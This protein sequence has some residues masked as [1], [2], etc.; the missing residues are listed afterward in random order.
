MIV[1]LP[2]LPVT[3]DQADRNWYAVFTLPQNEKS[4][5]R[6][7]SLREIEFFLPTYRTAR[8]WKNRQRVTLDIPL[9][10]CYLFARISSCER[11]KVLESPG[12]LRIV[13][14]R[15]EPTPVPDLA[16][17]FLRSGHCSRGIEPYCGMVVGKKVRIKCGAFEGL[18]GTLIRMNT[19]LRFVLTIEL[20]N[21]NASVEVDANSLELLN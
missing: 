17:E 6:H 9:F 5:A 2:G 18:E 21:Q 15:R 20:I 12:V 13:G 19:N 14:K 11:R 10:P 16:I 4:A 7:L 8:I 3:N 1:S